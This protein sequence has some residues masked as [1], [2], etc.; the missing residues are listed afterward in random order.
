MLYYWSHLDLH[1]VFNLYHFQYN[2]SIT[3]VSAQE[4]DTPIDDDDLE[5]EEEVEEETEEEAIESDI[6]SAMEEDIEA[7]EDDLFYRIRYAM[8]LMVE[9]INLKIR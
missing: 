9:M 3:I 1:S 4:V 5:T 2:G 6:E 7:I 8:L